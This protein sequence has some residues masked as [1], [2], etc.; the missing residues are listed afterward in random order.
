[1]YYL[2]QNISESKANLEVTALEIFQDRINFILSPLKF[3][4]TPIKLLANFYQAIINEGKQSVINKKL[5]Q[6][7][8]VDLALNQEARSIEMEAIR[9]I[10]LQQ[11]HETAKAPELTPRQVINRRNA[12]APRK[13]RNNA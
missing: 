4:L 10:Q 7:Q 9:A 12:S 3:T 8:L 11:L 2:N 13:S 6:Q 5:N 1:M